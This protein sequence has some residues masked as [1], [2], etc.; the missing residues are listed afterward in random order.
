M[1][2]QE[3]YGW[4]KN[5]FGEIGFSTINTGNSIPHPKIIPLP[6]ELENNIS[7]FIDPNFFDINIKKIEFKSENTFSFL[8]DSKYNFENIKVNSNIK[9]DKFVILNQLNLAS[10][11]PKT[12]KNLD[13]WKVSHVRK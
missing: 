4:G 9:L 3:L 7:K 11:F 5:H 1:I 2:C 10:I 6:E 13:P 8:I 12:K